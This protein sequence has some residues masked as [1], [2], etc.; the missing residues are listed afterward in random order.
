MIFHNNSR[1]D[2]SWVELISNLAFVSNP[3]QSS[4]PNILLGRKLPHEVFLSFVHEATH[5]W[6]FTSAWGSAAFVFHNSMTQRLKAYESAVD[7]STL[8]EDIE[9]DLL[10][11][12]CKYRFLMDIYK[13]L[14]E[15]IALFAEFDVY[16]TKTEAIPHHL[17]YT[18]MMFRPK[19][20][21]EFWKQEYALNEK[22]YHEFLIQKRLLTNKVSQRKADCLIS[23]ANLEQSPYLTGYLFVKNLQQL[24]IQNNPKFSDPNIFIS[25]LRE[26]YFND[27][28]LVQLLFDPQT[29]DEHISHRMVNHFMNRTRNIGA[30]APDT[31]DT[32]EAYL[33]D[34][35]VQARNL[36]CFNNPKRV[37][38][39]ME[40]FGPAL[41]AVDQTTDG[42]VSRWYMRSYFREANIK[43]Y[44]IIDTERI[45][46]YVRY[47]HSV[48]KHPNIAVLL[49]TKA[50]TIREGGIDVVSFAMT[51]ENGFSTFEGECFMEKYITFFAISKH[52]SL[53]RATADDSLVFHNFSDSFPKDER[54]QIIR[55]FQNP[56][57]TE[58]HLD[59]EYFDSTGIDLFV[60][61]IAINHKDNLASL[62][63]YYTHCSLN[64]ED[65][66][67]EKLMES[68]KQRGFYTVLDNREDM[69]Q[70]LSKLSLLS[71]ANPISR[72]TLKTF[73]IPMEKIRELDKLLR[74][75]GFLGLRINEEFVYVQGA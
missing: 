17:I 49:E 21:N 14:I 57:E 19:G 41:E 23:E 38:K 51:N 54:Q 39:A 18:S 13:P 20:G 31:F 2:Q 66:H 74:S 12:F 40:Y 67:L 75:K 28:E 68:M 26:Y 35:D 47:P 11:D 52:F 36:G 56:A 22:E 7:K 29:Q 34:K 4:L 53:F 45:K 71:A 5:H 6:T 24:L 43:C 16:P 30:L 64:C 59:F 70:L 1:L 8:E 25:F 58:R 50:A 73:D 60:E 63:Q 9:W 69:L 48:A 72:E 42:E 10:S 3:D 15:G 46:V 61:K 65:A 55:Y 33:L 27:F 37:Q 62:Y 32:L 44:L